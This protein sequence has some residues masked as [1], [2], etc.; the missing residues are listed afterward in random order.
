MPV[1]VI[2]NMTITDRAEYDIYVG[3]FMAVFRRFDGE[4][5]A[6]QDE[7][8]ALEGAWP[9]HRTILLKFP[10]RESFR[11]WVESPAYREI[12]PHRR[13]GTVSNVVALE[14]LPEPK[15]ANSSP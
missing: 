4:V 5:L 7:P 8:V 13:K 15:P 14:G 1:Y 3:K 9:H 6:V 11:Q 2:N 10:S 12:V